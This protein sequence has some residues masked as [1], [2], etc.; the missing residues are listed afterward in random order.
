MSV[1]NE[2]NV[3]VEL[4]SKGSGIPDQIRSWAHARP[5]HRTYLAMLALRE[6]CNWTVEDIAVSFGYARG[7]VSRILR[8]VP[9]KVQDGALVASRQKVRQQMDS[10]DLIIGQLQEMKNALQHPV[11]SDSEHGTIEMFRVLYESE[12][13]SMHYSDIAQQA[14][15][16]ETLALNLITRNKYLFKE[17]AD[18]HF[19]I[20]C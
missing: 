8:A 20:N 9:S 17:E 2:I 16:P 15:V 19:R 18:G 6:M 11:C 7:Q 3:R 4:E 10:L 13:D 14:G 5:I 12:S 1:C